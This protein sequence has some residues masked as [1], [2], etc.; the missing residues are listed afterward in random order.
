MSAKITRPNDGDR[1]LENLQFHNFSVIA[2]RENDAMAEKLGVGLV[3]SW[4]VI[5]D[6]SPSEQP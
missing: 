6:V 1:A 3:F 5:R 4:G 2:L